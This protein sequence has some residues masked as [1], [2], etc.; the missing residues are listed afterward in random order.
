[1]S[2]FISP[3]KP[4]DWRLAPLSLQRALEGRFNSI[5]VA[6]VEAANRLLEWSI[7]TSSGILE[8]G[9]DTDGNAIILDGDLSDCAEFAVWLRS[10]VPTSQALVF[11]DEDYSA[12]IE[13][14]LRTNTADI[15]LMFSA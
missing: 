7:E 4:T 11:Y 5:S 3:P 9:L 2:F 13:L 14:T 1:M 8:G 6:Q 15:I 12:D 10:L